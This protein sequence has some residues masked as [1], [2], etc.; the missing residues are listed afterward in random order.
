MAIALTPALMD[1]VS[2][3]AADGVVTAVLEW[4]WGVHAPGLSGPVST[5][6]DV[7]MLLFVVL[8]G[9]SMDDEVSLLSSIGEHWH[10]GMDTAASPRPAG[11]QPPRRPSCW[12]PSHP[13]SGWRTR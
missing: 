13:S 11:S 10:A 5:D 4:G 7:P 9:R 8:F 1:L 6:A 12:R 3:A 2:V